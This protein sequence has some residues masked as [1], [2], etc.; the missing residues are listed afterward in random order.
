MTG[1]GVRTLAAVGA[2][3]ACAVGIALTLSTP[4]HD[5]HDP[6]HGLQQLDLL[7]LDEPAPA[8]PVAHVGAPLLLV[9]CEGCDPPP[10][11]AAV[12]VTDDPSV[13]A[14]VALA[15]TDGRIG[16]GYAVIDAA[17]RL[18]YRTFDPGLGDHAEEITT[19]LE[20]LP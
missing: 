9:V 5:D 16:P 2:L 8:L 6:V 1:R 17:G 11:D 19:L 18:R 20:G 4:G 7:Y 3:A 13:A 15:R 10:V 12:H 14:A